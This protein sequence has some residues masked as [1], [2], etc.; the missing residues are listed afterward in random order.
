M[1]IL[2][3]SKTFLCVICD[4]ILDSETVDEFEIFMNIND[5]IIPYTPNMPINYR[6][7][8]KDKWP[9]VNKGV[10]FGTSGAG[11]KAAI[12]NYFFEKANVQKNDYKKILHPSAY[13]ARSVKLNP[14][15]LVEPGVIISSQAEIGFGVTIKR[16][17]IIGHHS[18]IGDF[19]DIDPGGVCSGNVLIGRG[20]SIGSGTTIKDGIAIG[21]NVLIGAGSVVVSDIPENMIAFGNPCKV[22]RANDKWKI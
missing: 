5:D 1:Q 22:V 21:D 15:V 2:G 12:Y 13:I 18:Q 17:S 8:P 16:G 3:I 11:N 20:C 14:G 4:T 10:V 9:V 19:T 6:I 7:V